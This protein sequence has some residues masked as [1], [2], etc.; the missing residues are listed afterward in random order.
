M[1]QACRTRW[2]HEGL[3]EIT[4]DLVTARDLYT[5]LTAGSQRTKGLHYLADALGHTLQHP[6]TA[7]GPTLPAPPA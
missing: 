7:H 6:G 3:L 5:E 4:L 1:D 2:T